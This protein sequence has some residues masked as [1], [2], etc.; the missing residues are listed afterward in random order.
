MDRVD[1]SGQQLHPQCPLSP[2][3]PPSPLSLY[4]PLS[5][6]IFAWWALAAFYSPHALVHVPHPSNHDLSRSRLQAALTGDALLMAELIQQWNAKRLPQPTF[7]TNPKRK[8]LLPQTHVAATFLLAIADPTKI[9]ALPGGMRRQTTLFPTSLTEKI[10]LDIDAMSSEKMHLISPD[11]AFV[12]DYSHPA[13]VDLLKRQSTDLYHMHTPSTIEEIREAL[14]QIGKMSGYHN[15]A[16]RLSL[17]MEAAQLAIDNDLCAWWQEKRPSAPR[18]LYVTHY[19]EF[20]TPWKNSITWQL[21]ERLSN[22]GFMTLL[23]PSS[24]QSDVAASLSLETIHHLKP[25]LL[26]IAVP[27]GGLIE[28][29][30]KGRLTSTGIAN[31]GNV[32]FLQDEVQQ[33]PTQYAILAYFDLVNALK[34][35]L[36]CEKPAQ[37]L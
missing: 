26:L 28:A 18:V 12:A 32:I 10:P 2:P 8:K 21:L 31:N 33:S 27:T 20:T 11:I 29:Q 17:F 30:V 7:T 19:G 35:A 4:L 13:L 6:F 34:T 9:I 36:E 16:L 22:Q 37:L 5:L 25:H 14:L 23:Q 1:E 24:S 3:S 15:E